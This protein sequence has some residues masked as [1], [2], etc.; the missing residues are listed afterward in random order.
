VVGFAVS[1]LARLWGAEPNVA[2]SE[3]IRPSHSR[4]LRAADAFLIPTFNRQVS[5]RVSKSLDIASR[6]PNLHPWGAGRPSSISQIFKTG[7]SDG[8]G[9]SRPTFGLVSFTRLLYEPGM[10]EKREL[11]RSGVGCVRRDL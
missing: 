7:I 3:A 9:G 6:P 11:Q 2:L 5:G 10:P 8:L 4:Y 1:R